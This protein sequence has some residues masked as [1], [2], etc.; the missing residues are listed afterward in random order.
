MSLS[1]ASERRPTSISELSSPSRTKEYLAQASE[2]VRHYYAR[3][4]YE[5]LVTRS[6]EEL[7][8][9]AISH[10]NMASKRQHD[11]CVIRIFNPSIEQDGWESTQTIIE[12]TTPDKPFL[13]R[14]LSVACANL[15]YNIRQFI[16]PVFRV[17]R[18]ETGVLDG[19]V[20][21]EH[22]DAV[23]ESFMQLHIDR[24]YDDSA[25]ETLRTGLKCVIDNVN[26]V[27]DDWE[28][29]KAACV[30]ANERLRNSKSGD[31]ETAEV[32]DFIEW[33][34]RFHFTFTGYCELHGQANDLQLVPQRSYGIFR[35]SNHR[36]MLE[37]SVPVSEL[38][39]VYT[40]TL[41]ATKSLDKA[42]IIHSKSM[43]II[44]FPH[45]DNNNQISGRCVI[46]GF[47]TSRATSTDLDSIPLLRH[48]SI[49]IVAKSGINPGAHDGKMLLTTLESFPRDML[50]QADERTITRMCRGIMNL[51]HHPRVRL[52]GIQDRFQ[53]FASCFVYIPSDLYTRELRQR[54]QAIMQSSMNADTVEYDVVF[55]SENSQARIHYYLRTPQTDCIAADFAAIEQRIVD[56]AQSWDDT[57]RDL[58]ITSLDT[59]AGAAIANS[60]QKAIPGSYKEQYN[61]ETAARDL[62]LLHQCKGRGELQV[63]LYRDSTHSDSEI[64][65]NIY[66]E[67]NN[68]P[69]SKTIHILENMG[70]PVD[71]EKPYE[72]KSAEATLN[73]RVFTLS[74]PNATQIPLKSIATDFQQA[75]VKIW[76]GEVE[77]DGMNQLVLNAGLNWRQTNIL[78]TYC[79]YLLQIKVP[80]SQE[81]MIDC[82][83]N[84]VAIV[85]SGV[86]IFETRFNPSAASNDT[87]ELEQQYTAQL[88]EVVSL[89]ED[90]I[91][92]TF[93]DAIMASVR[94][95]YF[96]TDSSHEPCDYL[97]IKLQPS[98]I[99]GVPLPCPE[100]EIF[101]CSPRVEAV[102]LR[103][104]R[105]ARGGLRWSDRR[106]D[107]RTEVLGLMKA[108]MVKN[109]VIVPVGS[110]GGFVVKQPPANAG[111]D[112]L[113]A[114]VVNCYQTFL[115]GMLNITDNYIDGVVIPPRDVVRHDPDDPYLVV[116]ADKGTATFSDIANGISE[117]SNFW[118]GD[119]F[120]S[121]GSVGYDHKGMGITAK[122]AWE[123]VKRHFRELNLNTQEEQF[124]VV[125]IGDMGGDVFGNGMLLSDKIQLVGAFN[126]M[127][128]FLD[129][130]PDAAA[131]YAE[132]KR[133]FALPR[134]SWQD[135]NQNL[136]SRGGGV[137]ARSSKSIP[138]SPEVQSLINVEQ[139][140]MAP[141]ELIHHL[142]KAKVD[143]LWNGG[144][145]TYIKAS[146]ETHIDAQDKAN[147]PL[148][149][150]ARDLQCRVVGEGGN[151]GCTQLGR[152]EFARNGGKI[153]T[154]A[155][156]NS[157]GVDCSD[158][159]VNI[160]ILVDG[161]VSSGALAAE[162]RSDFLA[163]MTDNV[164]E[165][166]L[167]DN[168][169]QTQCLSLTLSESAALLEEHSRFISDMESSG[170]L[171]RQIEFLPDNDTIAE[172]K[173]HSQGLSTPELAVI[174]AYS[175]MDIYQQLLTTDLLDDP[176][177]ESELLNYF[178][179]QLSTQY[180]QQILQHQLRREIIATLVTNSLVNRLGPT[181][182]FRLQSELGAGITEIATAYV[183]VR[184]LFNMREI[185]HS[186]E[187]LDNTVS[188]NTQTEMLLMV[189]GWV[190]RSIHW[191][192]KNNR[193][194][195]RVL[196]VIEY[197]SSG[198]KE[199][200][201]LVPN[202]LAEPNKHTYQS[203]CAHFIKAGVPAQI[204]ATVASVV[205][206]SSAFDILDI[207][208]GSDTDLAVSAGTYY[209]LGEYLQIQ[210]LREQ[211][212]ALDVASHWHALAKSA[213]RSDLHSQQ[214][215]L[216]AELLELTGTGSSSIEIIERWASKNSGPLEIYNQRLT[217]L[218]SSGS[219]D[220]A[221][222]SLAVNEVQKLLKSN[223]P[224]AE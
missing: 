198:T 50:L 162:K 174:V 62:T 4:P 112:E 188:S 30:Q 168:Y 169:Q 47:F 53:R 12:I 209:Q 119:A 23:S 63:L 205:P 7:N 86:K 214:R 179:S 9:A 38:Q 172:R 98:L 34:Q 102:H 10:W 155:I 134:S 200:Q 149:V 108:Q 77:D 181:F 171:N 114:E 156:D 35:G 8:R 25:L 184:S 89:D 117:E 73:I 170:K 213:L 183:A 55:S 69:L 153:Y 56:A 28:P 208:H 72:I 216:S 215:H 177:F 202:V 3:V 194:H 222:L 66:H 65:F 15:G 2:L 143:L 223:R 192:V 142:L 135:Y 176:F 185:W 37:A 116:A 136:I 113:M 137:Y 128:I 201:A 211:I 24:Q 100:F 139:S 163:A 51:E 104:G 132:R 189:R 187:T 160:K 93:R 94:T 164:S 36:E 42:Q 167:R 14:S 49:N 207:A 221:M 159:E 39:N 29:M 81:Y 17:L 67:G 16:H 45:I 71:G 41:H 219:V 1:S 220:Y 157:A 109:S 224:T 18:T 59:S 138:L 210:W 122:G 190:E 123:S 91:L 31:F 165:L 195:N 173:A 64:G 144:I 193:C 127:H 166:V 26:L 120:A 78:R 140:D 54:V 154:D 107:F 186:I 101:V 218:K 145:G 196:P 90:R 60:L 44:S 40:E 199:L 180:P 85:E 217:D 5:D 11:D 124:T 191:L 70:L 133:L 129:P 110:K 99:E 74:H 105:V 147:D 150:D 151:L 33:L 146:G 126:H 20:S 52:F 82:L 148:R 96:K 6:M 57:L 68:V 61:T 182:L 76:H 88:D 121:G 21:N 32:C 97:T 158:H 131:S 48:K 83:T 95:N 152:I 115:R 141:A 130:T 19:M 13:V 125:G 118:L 212:G 22:T 206:L 79:K 46:S 87:A 106:E 43:D 80:Y 161:L 92:R 103:G 27:C 75:F 175:K 204:A 111:R 84:N 197:F 178:P 58:L 203:R